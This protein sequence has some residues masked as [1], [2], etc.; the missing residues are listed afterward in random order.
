[1]QV[2]PKIKRL[3]KFTVIGLS[4]ITNENGRIVSPCFDE[5]AF[6]FVNRKGAPENLVFTFPENSKERSVSGNFTEELLEKY[7][8]AL[9]GKP[10]PALW[11][12]LLKY[13]NKIQNR[14]K[15]GI[16]YGVEFGF[17]K[18]SGLSCYIAGF[19]V[20]EGS[21]PQKCF[22]KIEIPSQVYAVF[23]CTLNT[24]RDVYDYIYN[25]WLPNSSFQRMDGPEFEFY[26]A[27]FRGDNP[28]SVMYLYIPV[29]KKF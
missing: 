2:D 26:D 9:T 4:C 6:A 16:S 5:S 17:D 15:S 10:V 7:G 29:R 1:M 22:V 20:K 24:L 14:V 28:N 23:P 12:L 11:D 8:K 19:P 27:N 18:A 21:V 3:N 25:E 13:E